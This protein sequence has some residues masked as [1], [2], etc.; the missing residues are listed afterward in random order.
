MEDAIVKEHSNGQNTQKKE[1][2]P[3]S[4]Q[5]KEDQKNKRAF[6]SKAR[7][8]ADSQRGKNPQTEDVA[9]RTMNIIREERS[10]RLAYYLLHLSKSRL[11]LQ[12]SR[13][14]AKQLLTHMLNTCKSNVGGAEQS[15][16]K[17]NNDEHPFESI[18]SKIHSFPIPL[19][20]SF[21]S[22]FFVDGFN[23]FVSG[24]TFKGWVLTMWA[25]HLLFFT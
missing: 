9:E 2:L 17:V 11:I 5:V 18:I 16:K 7:L 21:F 25:S 1:T 10:Q 13:L 12:S 8:T 23:F 19:L 20:Y 3:P 15:M 22:A 6:R 24:P 4:F 14:S